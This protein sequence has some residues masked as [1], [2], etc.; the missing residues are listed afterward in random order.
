[1]QESTGTPLARLVLFMVCLSIAG[2][3][4]AGAHYYAIDLPQQ[5]SIDAPQ[6]S[7]FDGDCSHCWR[8]CGRSAANPYVCNGYCYFNCN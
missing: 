4:V 3:I 2:S 8:E 6:N 7:W 5:K 1:M